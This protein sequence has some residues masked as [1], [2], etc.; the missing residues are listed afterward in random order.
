MSFTSVAQ[1]FVRALGKVPILKKDLETKDEDRVN[2]DGV[3]RSTFVPSLDALVTIPDEVMNHVCQSLGLSEFYKKSLILVIQ[4]LVSTQENHLSPA[5]CRPDHWNEFFR[6]FTES[7]RATPAAY[8]SL[9]RS[10]KVSNNNRL[11]QDRSF[12]RLIML[13]HN[14]FAHRIEKLREALLSYVDGGEDEIKQY[15]QV[16]AVDVATGEGASRLDTAV[17]WNMPISARHV[18]S[19]LIHM[20]FHREIDDGFDLFYMKPLFEAAQ[21]G[22]FGTSMFL[23]LAAAPSGVLSVCIPNEDY[24]HRWKF[25]VDFIEQHCQDESDWFYPCAARMFEKVHSV[26]IYRPFYGLFPMNGSMDVEEQ[27][28]IAKEVIISHPLLKDAHL[29]DI[30]IMHMINI[31]AK[32]WIRVCLPNSEEEDDKENDSGNETEVYEDEVERCQE[33]KTTVNVVDDLSD[34]SEDR[35]MLRKSTRKRS[36][37]ASSSSS[38][39]L[40]SEPSSSS[41]NRSKR[42]RRKK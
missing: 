29:R 2:V 13:L 38:S 22:L 28:D 42:P 35:S 17:L 24:V 27:T 26:L 1:E 14:A 36:T 39:S 33:D 10:N 16:V 15:Y 7:V 25:F 32:A 20:A 4:S 37:E 6:T 41:Q 9:L 19:L 3:S 40:G 21:C 31:H 34:E 12:M 5:Q 18:T 30:R 8:D 11:G 23:G